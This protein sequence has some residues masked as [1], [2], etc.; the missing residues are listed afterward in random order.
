MTRNLEEGPLRY[1]SKERAYFFVVRAPGAEGAFSV[2]QNIFFCP[3]CGQRL[4][5]DLRDQ[6]YDELE[7]LFPSE[8]LDFWKRQRLA[9]ARFHSGEWWYGRYDDSGRRL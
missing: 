8:D 2:V 1:D 6:L 7:E 5:T 9:P 3:W 4:P